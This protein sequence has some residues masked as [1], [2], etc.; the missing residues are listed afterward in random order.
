M[1]VREERRGEVTVITI[2][3]PGAR[4][5]VD[6]SIAEGIEAA[7]DRADADDAVRVVVLTGA[8][9]VFCAGADLRAAGTDPQGLQTERGGFAGIV[10]RELAKPVIAAVNGP[11][12]AGGFEIALACDLVVASRTAVFGLP[13]VKRGLVAAAGGLLHLGRR[14][15]PAVALELAMTGDPIDAERAAGLGLVNRVVEP[16]EE[17]AIALE[18]AGRIAAN[19]PLAVRVS[20]RLVL[21]APTVTIGE[22]WSRTENAVEEI[23]GSEDFHEGIAAFLEK[24]EPVWTGR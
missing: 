6:R 16:G 11:A 14:V 19:G 12:L 17:L 22:G 4:N 1:S 7:L 3:R 10:R 20:R 2:D 8:G 13:E 15:A 23:L 24:R 5:A 18:L 21:E 9:D